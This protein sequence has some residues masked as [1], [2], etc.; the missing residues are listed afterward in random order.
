MSNSPDTRPITGPHKRGA[1]DFLNTQELRVMN[2]GDAQPTLLVLSRD[3]HVIEVVRAASPRVV[4]VSHAPDVDFVAERLPSLD[5][6]VLVIDMTS[7]ADLTATIAQLTQHF[8]EVVVVV[9]GKRDDGPALMQLTAAGSVF[10]FLL[11]PLSQGQSRLAIAA[12]IAQHFELRAANRRRDTP[13]PLTAGSGGNKNYLASYGMLAAGLLVV[14]GGIWF[15][16]S[17]FTQAPAPAPVAT[18]AA[19][20]APVVAK[21][22]PVDAELAQADE[23]FN[24]GRY[25]E[26]AGD[27]A[28]DFYRSALALDPSNEAAKAGLRAVADKVLERAEQAVIAE[29][30]EEAVR[31][32]EAARDIDPTH[33]RL[34]FLDTQITRERERLSLSQA[35]DTGVRVRKL[36]ERAQDYIQ[37]GALMEPAGDNARDVLVQA[38]RLDATDPAVAQGT[39]ELNNAFIAAAGKSVAAGELDKAQQFVD[40]ARRMGSAGAQLSAV[41]RSIAD[42]KRRASAPPEQNAATPQPNAVQTRVALPGA[43]TRTPEQNARPPVTSANALPPPS[44]DTIVQAADLPRSRTV[45]PVYP[46]AAA[47][48]GKEGWVDIEF[49]I[50]PDGVPQDLVVRDANPRRIFDRA[51]LNAVKQWRWE[52]ILE[53][54]VAVAK[55]AT[56]RVRFQLR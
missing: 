2:P 51:A 53:G 52:P 3:A 5:L 9:V 36:V 12:A 40:A 43:G 26:P 18:P 13:P 49:V 37:A 32:V 33:P 22:N 31:G 35:R 41:E 34:G 38:R 50:N 21:P 15:A 25:L 10:R 1:T 16:I 4:Q 8:P 20:Q 23:A 17:M 39:R 46:P 55:R 45:P 54:N 27:S 29:R 44:A 47:N 30:L 42:A 24:A 7:V 6:G 11:S 14:I 19:T 28:L 48:E 56:L